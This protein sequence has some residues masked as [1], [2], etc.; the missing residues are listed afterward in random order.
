MMAATRTR[1]HRARQAAATTGEVAATQAALGGP[2]D[3]AADV[4]SAAEVVEGARKERQQ[5]KLA[6]GSRDLTRYQSVI[7]VEYLGCV[8]LTV[9]TPVATKKEQDGLSPYHGTDMVKLA[10]ITVLFFLLGAI[11]AGGS[12]AGRFAAWFGGLILITDGMYEASNIAKD[13]EILSGGLAGPA[14]SSDGGLVQ[15]PGV[16]IPQDLLA[17]VAAGEAELTPGGG[18]NNA[19]AAPPGLGE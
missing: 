12:K 11:S 5:R 4:A 18:P 1:P 9:L 16:S 19:G 3:P 7:L 14:A 17:G 6:A 8:L 13:L 2:E 10:A 15:E